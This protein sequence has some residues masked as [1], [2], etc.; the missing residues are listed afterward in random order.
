MYQ[1][2]LSDLVV[3][4]SQ[5]YKLLKSLDISKATGPDNISGKML[6]ECAREIPPSLCKVFNISLTLGCLPKDWHMA[7]VTP[8]FKKGSHND[9][10]NYSK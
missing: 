10:A 8:I 6:K 9:A 5:V 7:N 2:M 4:E 1:D 3:R